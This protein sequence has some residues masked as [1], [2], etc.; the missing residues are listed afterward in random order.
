[1]CNGTGIAVRGKFEEVYSF[2]LPHESQEYNSVVARLGGKCLSLLNH[3][4]ALRV[5]TLTTA[6]FISHSDP[7]HTHLY[8]ARY[9][10]CIVY[11]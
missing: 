1:M 9:L 3:I 11:R 10:L 4:V 7:L 8:T 5:L 2:L 6:Y